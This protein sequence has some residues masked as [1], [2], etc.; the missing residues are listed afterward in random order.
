MRIMIGA[1]LSVLAAMGLATI[2]TRAHAAA[3]PTAEQA[4]KL[5]PIQTEV[6]YDVPTQDEAAQCTIAMKQFNGRSGWVVQNGQGEILRRFV[7]T[8]GDNVVDQWSYYKDGIEVYRD[9]DS[10]FNGKPD[11]YRWF[12]TAGTRWG[13]DKN[14][15]GRIDAWKQISAEETAAEIVRALAQRDPERFALVAMTT[16]EAKSLGLGEAKAEKLLQKVSKL[17]DAFKALAMRGDV[18]PRETKMSHFS[19]GKPGVVPAGTDDST[20]DITVYEHVAAIVDTQGKMSQ[21]VVGTLVQLGSVWRAIDVPAAGD[22]NAE[23]VAGFFFAPPLPVR[24]EATSAGSDDQ[25]Q[26]TIEELQKIDESIARAAAPQQRA[27]LIEKRADLLEQLAEQS[28]TPAEKAMWYRQ[29]ADMLSGEVQSGVYPAGAKRLEELFN[30]LKDRKEIDRNIIA[31]VRICQYTAE[32]GLAMQ[33]PKPDFIKI[34]TDWLKNLEQFVAEYPQSPDAAE[35][36]LQ[37]G[38]SQEFNGQEEAAAQWYQRIKQ[39]FPDSPAAQK[40]AGAKW[41][42]ESVGKVLAMSGQALGG[43]TIDLAKLRGKPVLIHYWTTWSEPSKADLATIDQLLRKYGNKLAAVG[44]NL[45]STSREAQ[46]AVAQL[47][48]SWP[49]IWEEGGL[50]SRPANQLGIITVPTT[51]LIDAQGRVVNRAVGSNEIEEQVKKLLNP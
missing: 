46:A 1:F 33:A 24:P 25:L 19:G 38:I 51:I 21:I 48:V 18:L 49:Q 13:I 9:I 44:I 27:Q 15:D 50:D 30:K 28:K 11:Q 6:D 45:D 29:L 23:A 4:L 39:N 47:R 5:K 3:A 32:Y 2:A 17:T 10:D 16:E 34:Q 41:R 12:N 37:L 43:G 36:M 31:H 8:N 40:A 20:R 7:D 35:A 26:K 42:L 14:E 22:A